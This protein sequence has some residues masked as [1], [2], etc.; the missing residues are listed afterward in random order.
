MDLQEIRNQRHEYE[1]QWKEEFACCLQ[2]LIERR[3]IPLD[4]VAQAMECDEARVCSLLR[5]EDFPSVVELLRL[6]YLSY[7]ADEVLFGARGQ[8]LRYFLRG[9]FFDIL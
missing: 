4:L 6:V 8:G 1:E 7:D 2:G 3:G 5:G 9:N